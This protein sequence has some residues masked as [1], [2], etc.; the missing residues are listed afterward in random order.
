VPLSRSC[1]VRPV[2][3][4]TDQTADRAGYGANHALEPTQRSPTAYGPAPFDFSTTDR[5]AALPSGLVRAEWA[6]PVQN[7][8]SHNGRVVPGRVSAVWRL[9]DGDRPYIK[10]TFI[11]NSLQLNVPT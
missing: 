11:A 6:T 8:K 2:G 4:L 9:P 1:G 5:F 7:W 10:G 3:E